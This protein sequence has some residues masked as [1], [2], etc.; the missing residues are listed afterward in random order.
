MLSK[1]FQYPLTRGKNHVP[2]WW[3][4]ID[5]TQCSQCLAQSRC[6]ACVGLINAF[7]LLEDDL[8]SI[9]IISM[10]ASCLQAKKAGNWISP[11]GAR[12]RRLSLGMCSGSGSAWEQGLPP[13]SLNCLS[14]LPAL[15]LKSSRLE[16]TNLPEPGFSKF[17]A[18][19]G[20]GLHS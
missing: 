5:A 13:Q 4:V 14:L 1:G 9:Q 18:K 17:E 16:Q 12:T 8:V 6:S 19:C 3:N 15:F 20:M 2:W 7:G 10:L 11:A